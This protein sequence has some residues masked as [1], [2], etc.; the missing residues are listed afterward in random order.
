MDESP[1]ETIHR[2]RAR[3]A[4]L[5]EENQK[6]KMALGQT[7]MSLAVALRLPD[8]LAQLLGLLMTRPSV[9]SE[10][11]LELGVATDV[12]VAIHRLRSKL[13]AYDVKIDNVYGV[14]HT[15]SPEMKD[16]IE[17]IIVR[18]LERNSSLTNSMPEVT[19]L[20][21]HRAYRK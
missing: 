17:Q 16:K 20:M 2:L 6:L 15:L 21:N 12:G 13:A 5:E 10:V 11:I 19:K 18:H 1:V 4:L 3:V 7:D 9:P 14:G 8:K